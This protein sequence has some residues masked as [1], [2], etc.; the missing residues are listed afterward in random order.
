M[1]TNSFVKILIGCWLI[2]FGWSCKNREIPI[3][4]ENKSTPGSYRSSTD[5]TNVAD[6]NW[7]AYFA[8]EHLI[9]LIDTALR[10]NQELNILLQEISISR[11]EIQA[12][13][14]EYL[15]FVNAGVGIGM[16]KAARYTRDGAVEHGLE[17]R[18]GKEFPEPFGDFMLGV[19]A[20]W[21]VDIWR[22]LRNAKDAAVL[23][24][25]ASIEGK[26]FMVTNLIAEIAESYY[27]LLALDNLLSIIEQNIEIQRNALNI[28]KQQKEAA[29]TTQL[30]VNRFEAQLLNTQ[31]LQY[32]IKQRITEAENHINFLTARFPQPV[33]R[34]T[35]SL[36]D[37][38]VDS[39]Q[40]GIPSQLLTHRPD[41][42][43]AEQELAA[44]K[45]DVKS[46]RAAFYPS[47]NIRAGVGLQAFNPV[48][49]FRPESILYNLAGDM[50]APIINRNAI[51][52]AYNN[53]KAQQV[54][55]IYQYEQ[56]ILNAYVDVLNQ[57]AKLDNYA[58]S[59]QTKSQQVE[60][61]RQSIT[62][63][64][65]LFNSARADYTEVL[66]TQREALEAKL[67]LVEIKS[68]Q[69]SAKINI[70]RALGGGW[71]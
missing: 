27:E 32:D 57:L 12:R 17:I 10:N 71:N 59:Y 60:I 68:K 13:K 47:L 65:S 45:L 28:V 15:P 5:T 33:V 53:A 63:A 31:N 46:A 9:A 14:G 49:F 50:M 11:N 44:S 2:S 18:P 36:L 51:K 34:S 62:I 56:S 55:A 24:Y 39:F 23:R 70:Y 16:D 20:S 42:R 22:K 4:S 61:L 3:R 35:Q 69:L 25:L 8:D 7:R 67:E 38:P 41:I 26:N 6:L 21:E 40:A 54:Q 30:A 19:S 1:K 66:L 43:R 29:K 48:V 64:N 37:I 52:A 58:K